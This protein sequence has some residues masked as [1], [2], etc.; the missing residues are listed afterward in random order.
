MKSLSRV[1]FFTASD[2]KDFAVLL[3]CYDG[4]IHVVLT[5]DRKASRDSAGDP[6]TSRCKNQRRDSTA[7]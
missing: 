5:D 7:G 4:A 3:R 2:F 6:G 1:W